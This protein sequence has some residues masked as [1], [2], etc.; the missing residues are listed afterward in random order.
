MNLKLKLQ[1]RIQMARSVWTAAALAP[2]WVSAA[3]GQPAFAFSH[4]RA[5]AVLKSPQS[6]R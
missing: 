5:K 2:L 6:K 4:P 1:R 3:Y